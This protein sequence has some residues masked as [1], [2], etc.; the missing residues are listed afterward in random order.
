MQQLRTLIVDNVV[1]NRKQRLPVLLEALQA[2]QQLQ[3]LDLQSSRGRPLTGADMQLYAA[4]T[5][6]SHLTRLEL[7]YDEHMVANGAAR[8]MFSEGKQLP[9][10]KVL[11]FGLQDW[12]GTDFLQ[13]FGRGDLA[14]LAAACPAL[15]ELWLLPCVQPTADIS[16]LALLTSVTFLIVGGWD[17]SA[18][19]LTSALVKL[20]QLRFLEVVGVDGFGAAGVAALTVLAALTRLAVE[21]MHDQV[22]LKRYGYISLDSEVCAVEWASDGNS[23]QHAAA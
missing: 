9:Q 12:D 2:M 5:A 4:L 1:G 13:P 17:S 22:L 3:H 19:A 6:S 11:R 18:P 8:Y 14:R 23:V 15:E 16:N 21:A 10:L 20:T 7:M